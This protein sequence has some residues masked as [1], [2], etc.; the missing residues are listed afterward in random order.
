MA[1]IRCKECG[2]KLSGKA[3]FCPHCGCPSLHE[4]KT[5][6]SSSKQKSENP[7]AEN[8]VSSKKSFSTL[9]KFC[10]FSITASLI[11]LVGIVFNFQIWTFLFQLTMVILLMIVAFFLIRMLGGGKNSSNNMYRRASVFQREQQRQ[12]INEIADEVDDFDG[13]F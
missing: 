10:I 12:S 13:G 8:K 11:T 9:E 7:K 3:S 6:F 4:E 1:L 5:S 2:G